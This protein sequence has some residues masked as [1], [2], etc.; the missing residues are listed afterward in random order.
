VANDNPTE[1]TVTHNPQ[2]HLIELLP[3][4]DQ[5][6]LLAQCEWVPLKMGEVLCEA[7]APLRNAYF[8][9]D[10]FISLLTRIQQ[11]PSLEVGMVGREGC[12]GATLTLGVNTSALQAIVQHGASARRA[13]ANNGPPAP[14]WSG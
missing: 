9:V 6:R 12:F 2:N 7:G 1:A 4:T 10:S 14:P 11:H 5:R 8:P 13:C 3:K